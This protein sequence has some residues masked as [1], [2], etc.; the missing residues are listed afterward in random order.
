MIPKV[1]FNPTTNFI[2]FGLTL[3]VGLKS[4][5]Y[6][7]R[8]EHANHYTTD[9]VGKITVKPVNGILTIL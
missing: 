9:A 1:V 7:S 8:G 3:L 2:I 5:I 4:L 6:Q